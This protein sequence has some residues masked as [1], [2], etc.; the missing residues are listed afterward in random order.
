MA[1]RGAHLHKCRA[2]GFENFRDVIGGQRVELLVAELLDHGDWAVH[3]PPALDDT[4]GRAA[5]RGMRVARDKSG[6]D[7]AVARVDAHFPAP[8]PALDDIDDFIVPDHD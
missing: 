8:Q 1:E 7:D 3:E 6:Q 5:D 2:A 4:A